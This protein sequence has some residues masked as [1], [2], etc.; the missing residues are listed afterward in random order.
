MYACPNYFENQSTDFDVTPKSLKDVISSVVIPGINRDTYTCALI[1][2][3]AVRDI[4]R[5]QNF[6]ELVLSFLSSFFTIWY[7]EC[8]DFLFCSVNLWYERY[9]ILT[10]SKFTNGSLQIIAAIKFRSG[11]VTDDLL[12]GTPRSQLKLFKIDHYTKTLPKT[13][14]TSVIKKFDRRQCLSYKFI[15]RLQNIS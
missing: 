8:S 11:G 3:E 9:R 10:I 12:A 1:R 7:L 15:K 13:I 6:L 4:K 14:I 5:F 2:Q